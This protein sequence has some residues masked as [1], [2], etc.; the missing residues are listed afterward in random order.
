M[1]AAHTELP[2]DLLLARSCDNGDKRDRDGAD[3][4]ALAAGVLDFGGVSDSIMVGMNGRL[5]FTNLTLRNPAPKFPL[6]TASHARVSGQRLW[7]L[8]VGHRA[9]QRHC[10]PRATGPASPGPCIAMGFLLMCA[11]VSRARCL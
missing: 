8:A 5:S 11:H 7:A 3:P 2:G 9:A 6:H 10:A 1:R 4:A